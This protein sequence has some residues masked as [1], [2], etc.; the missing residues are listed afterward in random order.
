M[1]LDP[2][3]PPNAIH[4]SYC[5]ALFPEWPLVDD[6]DEGHGNLLDER[7]RL[8]KTPQLSGQLL[9]LSLSLSLSDALYTVVSIS[10]Y[11]IFTWLP[12]RIPSQLKKNWACLVRY[13]I[14]R[15]CTPVRRD[16]EKIFFLNL[17]KHRSKC[18]IS[19]TLHFFSTE[20]I[21]NGK[22]WLS[23]DV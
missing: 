23:I 4:D 9:S 21:F 2:Q 8:S 5:C 1:F 10:T 15:V 20:L 22:V 18:H 3:R 14:L 16:N 13:S 17:P 12:A 19:S 7:S 6:E 11:L